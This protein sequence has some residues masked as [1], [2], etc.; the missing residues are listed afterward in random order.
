MSDRE[1]SI[2]L[3]A[4]R[5]LCD[6][7]SQVLVAID[8]P[9]ACG[10]STL[11]AWLAQALS[12]PLIHMDDFFLPPHLRDPQ[13]L[14]RP[15]ENV[16]HQRFRQ[17]VLDP[18]LRGDTV[19]Y[20]PW[21]CRNAAFGPEVVLPSAPVVVVEGVYALRPDLRDAY[22]LRIFLTAPWSVREDRLRQRGGEGCLKRFVDQW[23]PLEDHYFQAHQVA[24]CCHMTLSGADE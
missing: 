1:R 7:Q 13:R 15:G 21:Q 12:C 6:Q 9:C 16:D 8:G 18:L 10:K 11:G 5:T 22:D 23:I 14:A 2:L 17:E 20:R 19:R 3:S 24:Q 4:I